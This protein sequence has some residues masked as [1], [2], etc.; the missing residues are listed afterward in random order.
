MTTHFEQ[1]IV[2][3]FDGTLCKHEFPGVGAPEPDVAESVRRI[4]KAGYRIIISSCRTAS[5]WKG[6]KAEAHKNLIVEFMERHNIPFDEIWASDKPVAMA[7]IDDRAI[8]YEHGNW[9]H[10]ARMIEKGQL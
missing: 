10:I 3:D 8:R 1:N 2:I 6:Q 9:K 7:Y 5:Y 4:K